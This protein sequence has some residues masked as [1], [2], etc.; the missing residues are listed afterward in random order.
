MLGSQEVQYLKGRLRDNMNLGAESAQVKLEFMMVGGAALEVVNK[1]CYRGYMI[2]AG[3]DV[4]ESVID[5]TTSGWKMFRDFL[6]VR[7]V[8][9]LTCKGFSLCLKGRVY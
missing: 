1:F 6:P 3:G 7:V 5:R 4:E 2:S 8:R 9:V